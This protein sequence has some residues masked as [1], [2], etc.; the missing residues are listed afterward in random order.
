MSDIVAL[1][2]ADRPGHV[3]GELVRDFDLYTLPG[4]QSDV[5][6]A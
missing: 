3:P 4:R 6:R 1:D 5:H 2:R